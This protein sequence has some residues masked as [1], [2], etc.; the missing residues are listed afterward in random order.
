MD[1]LKIHPCGRVV[2]YYSRKRVPL[3]ELLPPASAYQPPRDSS[4]PDVRAA[5]AR[6]EERVSESFGNGGPAPLGLSSLAKSGK[7]RKQ[8]G[9]GGITSQARLRVRDAAT[10][11]EESAPKGTLALWTVTLPPGLEDVAARHWSRLC[12]N[13]RQTLARDLR[14][15]GLPGEIVF[16]SEY[17]EKREK[18]H[19][20]PILHL[21]FLFQAAHRPYQWVYSVER[22]QGRWAAALRNVCGNAGDNARYNASSRV[23][24]VKKSAAAYLGKY[25][26]KGVRP[27]RGG[28]DKG[29]DTGHPRAWHGISRTLLRRVMLCTRR[30]R[31]AVAASAISYLLANSVPILKF[32]R[33]VSFLAIDG[34]PVYHCWYGDLR[35]RHHLDPLL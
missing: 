5:I 16:V 1:V 3:A 15:K 13:L 4:A 9:S 28:G 21:H 23:E 12:G 17:Q 11:L 25:M 27:L 18:N 32:N 6:E 30:L 8:R 7:P 29:A 24:A 35:D 14:A 22:Y 19:G 10:L 31:G 33:W 34:H 20:S 2:A 26:S